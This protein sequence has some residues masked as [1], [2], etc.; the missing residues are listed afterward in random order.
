MNHLSKAQ[1]DLEDSNRALRRFF[2][3]DTAHEES[4][5]LY[6]ALEALTRATASLL[7]DAEQRDQA[8]RAR[9]FSEHCASAA[10]GARRG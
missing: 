7:R 8:K 2:D 5:A 3:T 4:W 1:A 10:E 9:D 6:E